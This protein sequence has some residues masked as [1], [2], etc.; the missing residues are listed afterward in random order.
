MKRSKRSCLLVKLLLLAE[1]LH[2]LPVL[3]SSKVVQNLMAYCRWNGVHLDAIASPSE[4]NMYLNMCNAHRLGY[5][6][7]DVH[8]DAATSAALR[9][10]CIEAGIPPPKFLCIMVMLML[11]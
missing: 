8:Q 3:M 7:E 9:A 11:R 5:P 1:R 2:L 10:S 6:C 4:L